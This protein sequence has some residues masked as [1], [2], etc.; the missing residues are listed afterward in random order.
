MSFNHLLL[1]SSF[2]SSLPNPSILTNPSCKF[3]GIDSGNEDTHQ[4]QQSTQFQSTNREHVHPGQRGRGEL[5]W[6]AKL[7]PAASSSSSAAALPA[8]VDDADAAASHRAQQPAEQATVKCSLVGVVVLTP[9]THSLLLSILYLVVDGDV[10]RWKSLSLFLAFSRY[11]LVCQVRQSL[12]AEISRQP[13]ARKSIQIQVYPWNTFG[14]V[15][16]FQSM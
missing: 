4:V 15:L 2:S 7:S 11:K 9:H 14:Q 8:A 16:Q 3:R 6:D 13:N 10:G 1:R 12:R 5:G